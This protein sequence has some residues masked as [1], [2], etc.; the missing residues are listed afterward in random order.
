M[1]L[2]RWITGA[3]GWVLTGGPIGALLGFAVGSLLESAGRNPPAS[4]QKTARNDFIASLLVLAAAVMKADGRST[5]TEL[6]VIRRFLVQQFGS[7]IAQ[8]ALLTLRD[9]LPK[10]IPIDDVCRQIRLNMNYSQRMV[11][12]H[13][14]FNIAY[15]DGELH[16]QER[17]LLQH[18]AT[19]LGIQSGDVRSI[20]AMFAPKTNLQSDYQILEISA[21]ASDEEVRKAYRRM[22]MKH[23]PDKVAHLGPEFQKTATEKFQSVSA[24]Y[25]RIKKNRGM[26]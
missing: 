17:R 7:D 23:H 20:S 16:Q 11:L 25:E 1:G 8:S 10:E 21:S 3:L 22:S 18:M 6:G 13:F 24:A 15:A 5:R 14:L 9:L 26:K 19:Q 4:E 2:T 12:L